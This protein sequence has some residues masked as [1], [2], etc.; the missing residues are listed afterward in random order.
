MTSGRFGR[1]AIALIAAALGIL[2]LAVARSDP[3]GSFAGKSALGGIAELGAGWSL[4]AAGLLFWIRHPRNRFGPLL[5]AAGFAWFLPEWSNP[6]VD[7][8]LGFAVGSLCF[9]ACAPLI[10][11]AALAYPTGRLRSRL[12]V[13]PFLVQIWMFATP[14]IY[15]PKLEL[16]PAAQALLP[17]NPAYGLILNFRQCVLGGPLDLY[18]LAVSGGVS[19]AALLAGCLYFR[20]VERSFAD[21]I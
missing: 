13:V 2:S 17:L 7:T 10:A 21:I 9:V 16:G 15:L 1:L 19:V 4:V 14:C 3:V 5:T 8:A 6:G 18:S 11:H 20:R 12:D